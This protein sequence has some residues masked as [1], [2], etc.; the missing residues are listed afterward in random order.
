MSAVLAALYADHN[1]AVKVRTRLVQDG[2]PTDRVELTSQQ[3]L[4]QAR[5]VPVAA[6]SDKLTQ[7]FQQLFPD[8]GAQ[9]PVEQL[10]SAVMDGQ[11]VIAVHPR[12]DVET[13]RAVEIL[14]QA[15]PVQ[16]ASQDLDKQR[17]ERAAFRDR[18]EFAEF[19]GV[20]AQRVFGET[21]LVLEHRQIGGDRIAWRVVG[22]VGHEWLSSAADGSAPRWPAR[23]SA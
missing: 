8:Q 20:A 7:Y 18:A 2:F 15:E 6:V 17:F 1:S 22:G 16:I 21:P 11:A 4:G 9:V 19:V 10:Q 23:R 5:L 14:N 12:G 13:Q 3:E